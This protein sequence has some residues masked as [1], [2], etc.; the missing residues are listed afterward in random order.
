MPF[1]RASSQASQPPRSASGSGSD[2]LSA[3]PLD[4]EPP[5]AGGI[6]PPEAPP[7]ELA[8]CRG[9]GSGRAALRGG[10]GGST[11]GGFVSG[12]GAAGRGREIRMVFSGSSSS[13]VPGW[14]T[15]EGGRGAGAAL[16]GG[17]GGGAF[18]SA[19]LKPQPPQNLSVGSTA[20]PQLGQNFMGLPFHS[21]CSGFGSRTDIARDYSNRAAGE[22]RR[23]GT[24]ATMLAF[25]ASMAGTT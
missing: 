11:R 23:K 7:P 3:G 18:R 2:P 5:K 8:P 25:G 15:G 6:P 22:T 10:G 17:A 20:A 9:G 14:A 12:G 24:R 13:A 4:V 1:T 21:S 19:S 16:A